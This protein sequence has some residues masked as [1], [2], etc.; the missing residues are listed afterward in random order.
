MSGMIESVAFVFE[1]FIFIVILSNLFDKRLKIS[2]YTVI[3]TL[4]YLYIFSSINNGDYPTYIS[5]FAY[6]AII[7]YCLFVYKAKIKVTLINFFL[8]FIIVGLLQLVVCIPVYYIYDRENSINGLKS[9]LINGIGLLVVLIAGSKIHLKKVS[10]FIQERSW[11]IKV[12]FIFIIIY[13]FINAFYMK[14]NKSID[15]TDLIQIIFFIILFFLAINEWQKAIVDAERKRTQLEMNELYYDAYDELILLIRERQHDMK[16]HIN[17][18]LGMIYTI[19]NYDDLVESQKKYC[20]DVIGKNKE[21][22]LLLSI[23]NPLV[24]GFLFRKY[25]D[26][27]KFDI[28]IECK[29]A[30]KENNFFVPEYELIEMLGILIDNAIEAL[31]IRTVHGKKIYVEIKDTNENLQILVANISQYYGPDEICKFFQKDYSSK[32]K[33]HGIG[34]HKLKKVVKEKDG[35][36]MVTNEKIDEN[37][38]LQFSII[39]PKKGRHS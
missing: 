28:E 3:L 9:L 14:V 24:A 16:S 27:Q 11:I 6:L 8:S 39:L 22:K 26:A 1:A 15:N 38:Y 13:V 23:G 36:I 31:S 25:Q 7:V 12:A 32:G 34:L 30:S 10:D 35:D 20:D 29:V 33:G 37:N 4:V 2:F 21:T 19:D 5:F 17:A 18:I